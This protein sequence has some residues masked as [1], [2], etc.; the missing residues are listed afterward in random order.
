[1]SSV[2][3]GEKPI[4]WVSYNQTGY[5]KHCIDYKNY[6]DWEKHRN[7][8]RYESNLKKNFDS[9]N[10]SH[11]FRLIAMCTEIAQG[12]GFN[13]NRRNIDRDFLLDVKNHKYEYDD[14]IKMLDEKKRIMD[15]AISKSTLPEDID[16]NV[17]NDLLINIRKEQLKLS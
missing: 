3:K 17:V 12:K 6:K 13:V 7:P 1:M 16:A 10:V 11:A 14:V 2:S 8:V 4:C 15:D 5:Q 9:K